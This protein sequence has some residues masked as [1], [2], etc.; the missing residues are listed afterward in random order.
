MQHLEPVKFQV[1]SQK[2]SM[3]ISWVVPSRAREVLMETHLEITHC[4]GIHVASRGWLLS[5]AMC[6]LQ[7]VCFQG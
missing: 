4:S 6:L 1:H 5:L 2:L 7:T 3:Y